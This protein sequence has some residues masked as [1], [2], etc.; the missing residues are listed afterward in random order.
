MGRGEL[1]LCL[2]Y[3]TL[4]DLPKCSILVLEEPE[5]H[6]SPRSQD[7]LMNIV[8]R[9]CDRNA[10]WTIT[11]THSPTI[12]RHLPPN[13]VRLVARG[14]GQAVIIKSP[15]QLQVASILGGGV[16]L[17][18][19]ILVE[20]LGAMRFLKHLLYE[21]A[22]ELE[23]QFEVVPAG[24]QSEVAKALT[25]FPRTG[26]WLAALGVFDGDMRDKI[27]PEKFKRPHVFLPGEASPEALLRQLLH[28]EEA[29]A[30]IVKGVRK[31]SPEIVFATNHVEGLDDHEWL[32]EFSRVLS[33]DLAVVMS[34]LVRV[35]IL[36]NDAATRT[37]IAD[38]RGALGDSA[39]PSASS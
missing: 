28:S 27:N 6:V 9:F 13:H 15:N 38:L 17:K 24:S 20:D 33:L 30:E 5:T 16:A 18:G 2:S 31:A 22:P 39:G 3:W 10:I 12:V 1:A 19:L 4:G 37:F 32:A 7:S 26:A 14:A 8:A 11:T 35:W 25:S 29:R 23:P 34:A 21:M 36:R